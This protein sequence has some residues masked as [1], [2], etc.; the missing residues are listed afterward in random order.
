MAAESAPT[1]Q[2]ITKVADER[3]ATLIVLGSHG[4]HGLAG[5]VFGSVATAV[6]Q[7]CWQSVLIVHQPA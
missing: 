5:R 6:A 4:R 2:G 3:E 7:H 1:W